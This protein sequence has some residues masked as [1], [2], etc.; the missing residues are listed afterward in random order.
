MLDVKHLQ[1]EFMDNVN[2]PR[3][4]KMEEYNMTEWMDNLGDK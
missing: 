4:D 2:M 1:G 3:E